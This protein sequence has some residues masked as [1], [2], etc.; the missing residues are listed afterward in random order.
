MNRRLKCFGTAAARERFDFLTLRRSVLFLV[1]F[2]STWVAQAQPDLSPLS[3]VRSTS[4][5][6]IVGARPGYSPLMLRY[7]VANDTNLVLLKPALLVV[8]LERFKSVLWS[9][10]GLK[11]GGAWSGQV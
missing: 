9:E 1:L 7:D 11:P 2:L 6:F 5:Q 8:S 4:G 3:T 10:L